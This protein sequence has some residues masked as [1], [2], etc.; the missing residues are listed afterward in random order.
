M[1]TNWSK[2]RISVLILSKFSLTQF[3]LY[4]VKKS[5]WGFHGFSG[6]DLLQVISENVI[7]TRFCDRDIALIYYLFQWI[8]QYRTWSKFKPFKSST[9]IFPN[10]QFRPIYFNLNSRFYTAMHINMFMQHIISCIY[11]PG[12]G[13][14]LINAA[15]LIMQ[16]SRINEILV[17]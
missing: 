7:T 8:I 17:H 11:H 9:Q 10:Y 2:I 15:L 4:R 1:K 12:Q 3:I 16:K 13:I 14:I 5:K 6:N